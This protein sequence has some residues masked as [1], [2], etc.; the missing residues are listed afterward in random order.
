MPE[1]PTV[2]T[3]EVET[4]INKLTSI[5]GAHAALVDHWQTTGANVGEEIGYARAA[6]KSVVANDP[7][8]IEAVDRAGLG[9]HPAVLKFLAKQGRLDANMAGDNT[10]ARNN[11]N[12][13]PAFTPAPFT[14][15]TQ[16]APMG[17][18]SSGSEETRQEL[19]RLINENGPGTERYKDPAVQSR[20][21]RL[22]QMLAGS[23]SSIVGRGG[24]TS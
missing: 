16:P 10:V 23:G 5:G 1:S 9:N 12:S 4:A 15:R 21:Q 3:S 17:S 11:S 8:L 22:H 6:Y 7:G 2:P 18:R 19:N 13:A 14:N 24:R 20:I